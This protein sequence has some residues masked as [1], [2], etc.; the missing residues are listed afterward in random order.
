MNLDFPTLCLIS[1][2][3]FLLGLMAGRFVY[4]RRFRD[5]KKS[6]GV[7]GLLLGGVFFSAYLVAAT[8]TLGVM[9]IYLT[10]LPETAKPANFWVTLFFGLWIVLN[11]VFDCRR[12]LRRGETM[13]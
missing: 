6:L 5:F 12:I 11:L 8:I 1:V 7:L 3:G 9:I 13:K 10:N 4:G 2:P